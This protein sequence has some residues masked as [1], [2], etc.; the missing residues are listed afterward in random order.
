ML[1]YGF[2]YV[3]G[4]N[5]LNPISHQY[6]ACEWVWVDIMDLQRWSEND[7]LVLFQML[8]FSRLQ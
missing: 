1:V 6:F 8:G 4:H 7:L 5:V 3:Q 2:C